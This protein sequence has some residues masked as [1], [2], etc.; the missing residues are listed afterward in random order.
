MQ[1]GKSFWYGPAASGNIH[2][3][4]HSG[5]KYVI[6]VILTMAKLLVANRLF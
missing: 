2:I 1:C 6:S 4:H 3:D 5:G